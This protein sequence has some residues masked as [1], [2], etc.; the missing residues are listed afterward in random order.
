M[1]G[2]SEGDDSE[3]LSYEYYGEYYDGEYYDG[4]E[5]D[6]E[7]YDGDEYDGEYYD[8]DEYEIGDGSCNSGDRTPGYSYE[9]SQSYSS[10]Y[11]AG[12]CSQGAYSDSKQ[13]YGSRRDEHRNYS[14]YGGYSDSAL[15]ESGG[16]EQ[17]DVTYGR[18]GRRTG[19]SSCLSNV[20]TGRSRTNEVVHA[21]PQTGRNI[22]RRKSSERREG[23]R[24]A[25]SP[26]LRA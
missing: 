3:S 21:S 24:K 14:E 10:S 5:Y 20:R 18:S 15:C 6:G 25:S 19:E 17:E 4:D 22:A 12:S 8:G 23:S 9:R 7:Y 11:H 1:S 13:P 2:G 26:T 16:K